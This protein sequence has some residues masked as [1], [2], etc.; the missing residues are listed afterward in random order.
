MA[1]NKTGC[2]VKVGAGE[3]TVTLGD[4]VKVGGKDAATAALIQRTVQRSLEE[5]KPAY[6]SPIAFVASELAEILKA[7]IV[8]VANPPEI[9]QAVY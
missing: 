7:E 4:D 9:P 1:V 8:T 3:Y 2:T 5:Y 6:G